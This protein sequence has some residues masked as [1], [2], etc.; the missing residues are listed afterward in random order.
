M[1]KLLIIGAMVAVA[2]LAQTTAPGTNSASVNVGGQ[3]SI[4][5]GLV[6]WG[7][8]N[9][10]NLLTTGRAVY[11]DTTPATEAR[12][13]KR[14]DNGA[15]SCSNPF[16][17]SR[18]S[19]EKAGSIWHFRIEPLVKTTDKDSSTMVYRVETRS[20]DFL[21]APTYKYRARPWSI[22]GKNIGDDMTTIKDTVLIP[23]HYVAQVKRTQYGFVTVYGAQ[24]R[25]CPDAV[26]ATHG[27]AADTTYHDSVRVVIR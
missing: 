14:I 9:G 13:L 3:T 15:D 11:V 12:T 21:G 25:I 24:A 23:N 1:K 2:A 4:F 26:A 18:D 17:I 5:S 6:T 20:F 7:S 22:P 19:L 27:V 8:Y 16:W 10:V